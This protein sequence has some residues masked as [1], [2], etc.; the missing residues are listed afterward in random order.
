[1]KKALCMLLVLVLALGMSTTVFA[2][3]TVNDSEATGEGF[4]ILWDDRDD[5]IKRDEIDLGGNIEPDTAFWFFPVASSRVGT[6]ATIAN[7]VSFTV[8]ATGTDQAKLDSAVIAA[9]VFPWRALKD[10]KLRTRVIKGQPAIR[11][12]QFLEKNWNGANN[13]AG[14]RLRTVQRLKNTSDD[15]VDFEVTVFPTVDGDTWNYNDKGMVISGTVV[16]D[17]VDIDSNTGY[18]DLYNHI[19]AV[20]EEAVKDIDYDLGPKETL[21]ASLRKCLRMEIKNLI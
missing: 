12:I 7:P 20:A 3:Y 17:F 18:V 2:A 16:N 15:G 13:A 21:S 19:V 5:Q 9:G 11:D 10:V 8:T 4:S 1:M 6:P 14:I